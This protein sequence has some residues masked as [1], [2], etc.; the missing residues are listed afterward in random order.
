MPVCEL[1]RIGRTVSDLQGAADF[2]CA[3]IGFAPAGEVTAVDPAWLRVMGLAP[4]ATAHVLRLRL[5]AQEVEL[6]AFDP[7][8]RPYPGSRAANDPW[9]QHIAIVV[10]DIDRAWSRLQRLSVEAIS[11]GEPEGGPQ[12][13]PAN[14]GGVAAVKF[15][16]PDGHPL[17]LLQFPAGVGD[18]VWHGVPAANALGY[19]HSAIVVADAE[20]SLAFYTDLLGL[21][22]GGRSLNQGVE[23][24]RLDG[25]SDCLVDVIGLEPRQ[26]P[27]PHLELLGY[28]RPPARDSGGGVEADDRASSRQVY[29]VDDLDG[30]VGRL[31]AA[32][33]AIVTPGIVPLAGGEHAAAIR[34]PDG[35]LIVLCQ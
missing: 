32:G 21:R 29:R 16:D 33:V 13:L 7:P 25:L 4:A 15:R 18:P 30:L 6:A 5:G 19:D 27:T 10:D 23:Q 12:R 1:L 17:E 14:T 28:R 3:G 11:A 31:R 20:R 24:D 22:V 35:H 8:G 26:A 9:F 2:Y 34:D